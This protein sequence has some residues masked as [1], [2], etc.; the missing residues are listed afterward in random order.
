MK[1]IR[2]NC[3]EEHESPCEVEIKEPSINGKLIKEK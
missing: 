1:E 3:E 2:L